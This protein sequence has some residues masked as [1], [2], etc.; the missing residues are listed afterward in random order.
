MDSD[1]LHDLVDY[2]ETCSEY[3]PLKTYLHGFVNY[4]KGDLSKGSVAQYLRYLAELDFDPLADNPEPEQMDIEDFHLDQFQRWARK[5]ARNKFGTDE[6]KKNSRNRYKYM[7][8]LSLKKY[9]KSQKPE[10]LQYLPESRNFTK[11]TSQKH[12]LKYTEDQIQDMMMAVSDNRKLFLGISLMYY[13]GMRSFELLHLTPEWLEFKE[14]RIEVEI[15]PEYAKGQKENREKEFTF[16]KKLYEQDLKKYIL[17]HYDYDGSYEDLVEDLSDQ[18]EF[19]P[20]FNFVEDTEKT[21]QDLMRERYHLN[22]K[23]KD[24]AQR[25]GINRA[26]EFSSHKLRRSFIHKVYDSSNDLS[27]TAQVARHSKPSTTEEFYLQ[28]DKEERF[29]TYQE[30]FS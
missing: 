7:C 22:Q 29:D 15:P 26:D 12:T 27:R 18:E 23:L 6:T 28:R 3:Q 16:V 30:A 1:D 4:Y 10:L 21:Y 2:Y 20:V 8:F 9:I 24:A 17:D 14:E 13:G 19:E 25:A 5:K 11:P